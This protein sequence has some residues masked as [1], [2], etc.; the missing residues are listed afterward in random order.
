MTAFEPPDF[1]YFA[2]LQFNPSIYENT[3]TDS[4]GSLPINPTFNSVTTPLVNTDSI[5]RDTATTI[6]L[7]DAFPSVTSILIGLQGM[8][9]IFGEWVI[10]G[11]TISGAGLPAIGFGDGSNDVVFTGVN[12]SIYGSSTIEMISGLI[13]DTIMR[14]EPTFT[15][16]TTPLFEVVQGALTTIEATE[17]YT[18]FRNSSYWKITAPNIYFSPLGTWSAFTCSSTLTQ[19]YNATKVAFAGPTLENN[20]NTTLIRSGTVEFDSGNAGLGQVDINFKTSA[21]NPSVVSANITSSGGTALPLGGVLE[22]NVRTLDNNAT[23]YNVNSTTTTFN[24][25][26]YIASSGA[27]F[28]A[29]SAG[30]LILFNGDGCSNTGATTFNGLNSASNPTNSVLF[31]QFSKVAATTCNLSTTHRDGFIWYLVNQGQATCTVNYATAQIFGPGLT[32]GGTTTCSIASGGARMFR[33]CIFPS[34]SIGGGFTNGWF[35][36]LL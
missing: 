25:N 35:T 16:L 32:R 33:S 11:A 1:T 18:E 15:R 3:L 19:F 36:T 17:V 8:L 5:Q 13:T 23:L 21:A 24:A 31:V 22:F 12:A 9:F 4:A 29:G 27:L 26:V 2:G 10:T 14:L 20:C 34:G 7:F 28:G 30:N 6:H